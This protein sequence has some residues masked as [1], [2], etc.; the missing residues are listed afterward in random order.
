MLP[1]ALD[2]RLAIVEQPAGDEN[3][4]AIGDPYA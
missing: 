1:S 2:D 3:S 4:A